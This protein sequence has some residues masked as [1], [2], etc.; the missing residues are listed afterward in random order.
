MGM[1]TIETDPNFASHLAAS[2]AVEATGLGEVRNGVLYYLAGQA[3]EAMA[4]Y[5]KVHIPLPRPSAESSVEAL[6]D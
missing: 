1:K 2:Q 3:T 6:K 5:N 4:I